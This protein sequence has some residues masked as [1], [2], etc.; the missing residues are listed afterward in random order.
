[1][2]RARIQ[3]VYMLF[4]PFCAE[5]GGLYRPMMPGGCYP[6]EKDRVEKVAK[7]ENPARSKEFKTFQIHA[8][9]GTWLGNQ[10]LQTST[11]TP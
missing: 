5:S 9:G 6:G 11:K 2:H 8:P 4:Q 1:M 10:M 3:Y 7:G